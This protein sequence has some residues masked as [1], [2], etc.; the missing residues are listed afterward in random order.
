MSDIVNV[1]WPDKLVKWLNE[2]Q[3]NG[4][5]H[6]Y[7]CG[8]CR[9]KYHTRFKVVGNKLVRADMECGDHIIILDRELV[10]TKWGWICHTCDN[11]Q[12]WCHQPYDLVGMEPI[13]EKEWKNDNKV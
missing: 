1:P 4:F 3:H 10:A 7:T 6:P 8:H 9:D 13:E 11:V 5:V 12:T 2:Y